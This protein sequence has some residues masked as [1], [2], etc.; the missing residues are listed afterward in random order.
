MLKPLLDALPLILAV[1]IPPVI[2]YLR[3]NVLSKI[4]GKYLPILLPVAGGVLAV[5]A[6]KFGV[7]GS[8]LTGGNVTADDWQTVIV[9]VLTGMA[10]VGAHQA[11]KQLKKE[12]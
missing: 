8:V 12:S 1:V 9:A 3:G 6:A 10:S 4:P 5:I 2:A 7:D 11:V